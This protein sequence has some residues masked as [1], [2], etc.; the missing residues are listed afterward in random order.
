M[1][2]QEPALGI[3]ALVTPRAVRQV[4]DGL[5]FPNGIVV[6]PD[7]ATLIVAESFSSTLT[8]F[9]VADDGGLSHRR[10]WADLESGGDGICLDADGAVWCPA[11]TTCLR[12]R[13]GGEILQAV[14]LDR[15][16]FA[17]ALGGDDRRTLFLLAAEW[18][19]VERMTDEPHTGQ[20]LTVPAPAPGVGWP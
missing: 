11:G 3:I 6:T 14:D 19:G 2:G 13:E 17:C 5:A 1:G 9:T 20:V 15:N 10:V 4:A 18:R 7:N 16:G 8:A 12:V